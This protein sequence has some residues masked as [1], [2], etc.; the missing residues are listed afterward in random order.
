MSHAWLLLVGAL[1]PAPAPG[2]PEPED[3]AARATRAAQAGD[4]A[5][6]ARLYAE[7]SAALPHHAGILVALGRAQARLG[8]HEEAARTL[9]RAAA[10]GV[11]ADLRAL[12]ESFGDARASSAYQSVRRRFE[13]NVT[14]I[15]ASDVAFRLPRELLPE[16]LAYHAGEDAFYV[17]SMHRRKIVRV[18]RS[19]ATRDLVP[20]ARDGLASVIGIKLDAARGELWA[21]SCNTGDDPP[22]DP[23]D[24]A[25]R[26]QGAL[27]RY[28]VPSGRLLR[29]YD[30]PA[31][32]AAGADD[33]RCFND[34]AVDANGNV[35]LSA[36]GLGAFRLDRGRDTVE[37][38]VS[39]PGLLLNG[40]AVSD[41]AGTV[42]VAA[43]G[44]GVLVVDVAT[45]AWRPLGLPPTATLNGIDGLY[46][47]GRMLV[48]V[49]NGLANGPERVV[50]A[51][52]D[53]RLQRAERVEVLE[54]AHPAYAVPTT[55]VLVGDD[56]Y[57]VAAS[58]LE[59]VDANGRLAPEKLRDT[60]ILRRPLLSPAPAAGVVDDASMAWMIVRT[61]VRRTQKDASG[62]EVE[63]RF[64]YAG[65]MTY[66]KREGRWVRVANVSTFE[67]G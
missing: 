12:D 25:T 18:D 54:R 31:A 13:E 33:W 48:G 30:L 51:W 61:R 64:V 55:G 2:P 38:F 1:A 43:H 3:L 45:R 40:I 63:R 20:T 36:G 22:M 11:G 56:F 60:I 15:V 59:A 23:P 35:Y 44:R 50:R 47:R 62:K 24:P 32:A 49:Q 41:D 37:P 34:V 17:G 5:E 29:R 26:R 66:A 42:F 27:F 67:G 19:G 8:R 53:E 6:A 52:L 65:I 7:A 16:S 28:E 46:V 4:P 10:M 58:N 39:G 57:Y 9:S 14:P 21:T